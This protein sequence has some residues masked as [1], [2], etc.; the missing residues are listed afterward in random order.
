MYRLFGVAK[1]H[2]TCWSR[3]PAAAHGGPY[4]TAKGCPKEGPHE[5]RALVG[6]VTLWG[7]HAGALIKN[8]SLWERPHTGAGKECEEEGVQMCDG[9]ITAHIPC[10]SVPLGK[11]R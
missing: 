5:S 1:P 8:Y 4:T 6:P 3:D 2:S 11:R 9:L 7:T 10:P